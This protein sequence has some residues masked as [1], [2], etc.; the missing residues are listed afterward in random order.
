NDVHGDGVN[1]AARL[2]PLAEPGGICVS[3][4]VF[5]HVR[6][7]LAYPFE[8]RGIQ[9]L[10]N[11]ADPVRIYALDPEKIVG[12]PSDS[13]STVIP[14][15]RCRWYAAAPAV[16]CVWAAARWIV[17]P[18][19]APPSAQVAGTQNAFPGTLAASVA[20]PIMQAN[21][22]RLSMVVLPFANTTRDSEQE[23]FA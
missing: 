16:G 7:K 4:T 18:P 20:E 17:W 6:G 21:P 23:Y 3:A 8:E 14:Q 13:Q 15:E 2:E 5:E 11:I 1:V 9:T 10:K 19:R 12:L 22:P